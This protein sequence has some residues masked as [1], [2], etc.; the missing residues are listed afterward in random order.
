MQIALQYTV[1]SKNKLIKNRCHK[2]KLYP[3]LPLC[4]SYFSL[5]VFYDSLSSCCNLPLEEWENLYSINFTLVQATNIYGVNFAMVN[6]ATCI[7]WRQPW[8]VFQ[9]KH[10]CREQCLFALVKNSNF[11]A[12]TIFS[13]VTLNP[14]ACEEVLKAIWLLLLRQQ[15]MRIEASEDKTQ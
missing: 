5:S 1:V 12:I 8:R 10:Y 3:R 6:I 15:I 13:R 14:N 7:L 4:S 2:H 9:S 11:A